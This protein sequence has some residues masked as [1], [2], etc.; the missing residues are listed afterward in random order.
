MAEDRVRPG[1]WS[2]LRFFLAKILLPKKCMIAMNLHFNGFQGLVIR[3]CDGALISNCQFE[4]IGTNKPAVSQRVQFLHLHP[5]M[6]LISRDGELV[7]ADATDETLFQV[8]R[9]RK[10]D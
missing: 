9:P 6:T 2:K 10:Y 8:W 5:T 4:A 3:E 1:R 7:F